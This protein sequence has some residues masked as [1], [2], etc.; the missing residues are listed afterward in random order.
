[1]INLNYTITDELITLIKNL[2]PNSKIN[3]SCTNKDWR[4]KE[5]KSD[6]VTIDEANNIGFEVF[7]KEIITFYFTEHHHFMDFSEENGESIIDFVTEVK[8]I[9]HRFINLHHTIRA[10]L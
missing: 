6:Y 2:A 4:N 5:Y 7:E 8:K 9:L 1:V 10:N 3:I